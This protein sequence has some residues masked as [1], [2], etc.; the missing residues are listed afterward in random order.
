MSRPDVKYLGM[1]KADYDFNF[2]TVKGQLQLHNGNKKLITKEQYDSFLKSLPTELY[3]PIRDWGRQPLLDYF[4]EEHNRIEEA[5]EQAK[6]DE[7]H[8]SDKMALVDYRGSKADALVY[9]PLQNVISG[10]AYS[11]IVAQWNHLVVKDRPLFRI[12]LAKIEYDP[13]SKSGL[14]GNVELDNGSMSVKHINLYNPPAYRLKSSTDGP[15]SLPEFLDF[16]LSHLADYHEPTKQFLFDSITQR[17]N[18]R[19]IGCLTLHSTTQGTGKSTFLLLLKAL[20]GP[21]NFGELD[22]KHFGKKFASQASRKQING[23][24]EMEVE[25]KHLSIFK[26][27]MTNEYKQFERKH[28]DSKTNIKNTASYVATL[29][30]LSASGAYEDARRNIFPNITAVDFQSRLDSLDMGP[31][32]AWYEE[33]FIP[34]TTDENILLETYKFFKNRETKYETHQAIKTFT[35]Y[36]AKKACLTPQKRAVV[37]VLL[38]LEC[39]KSI[40]LSEFEGLVKSQLQIVG[41]NTRNRAITEQTLHEFLRSFEW[42]GIRPIA[43]LKVIV[44]KGPNGDVEKKYILENHIG[45]GADYKK[46]EL[47]REGL[48]LDPFETV[49]DDGFDDL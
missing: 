38:E 26:A 32:T 7:W 31:E 2:K 33:N 27:E 10:T 29:N 44:D 8:L 34:F 41:F 15:G 43:D 5:A 14:L 39:G 30:D 3:N 24:D 18:G 45:A 12:H 48:W 46:C 22:S 36:Q 6:I 4:L 37:E 13:Y 19:Q 9:L 35:Y 16:Q 40:G 11:A 21:E 23:I 20:V 42:R 49:L 1:L 28:V 47:D 17:L 25:K